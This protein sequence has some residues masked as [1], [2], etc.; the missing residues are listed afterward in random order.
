MPNDDT[1]LFCDRCARQLIPGKGDFYVVRIEAVADPS[2][3]V[4]DE[5]DLARDPRQEIDR[6]IEQSRELSQQE[7]MDQVY[8]RLTIY[9]CFACYSKWIEHPVG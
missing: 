6:L 8:R 9:L 3:P 5:E 2:P 4:F 1:P 7:L